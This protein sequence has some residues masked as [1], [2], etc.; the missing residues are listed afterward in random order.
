MPEPNNNVVSLKQNK[1]EFIHS[2]D[3]FVLVSHG[4]IATTTLIHFEIIH[5]QVDTL[6][7]RCQPPLLHVSCES[8]EESVEV[9][10]TPN[11]PVS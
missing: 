4:G 10:P 5:K 1:K 2:N 9:N 11:K 6:K 7:Q 3:V 8:I